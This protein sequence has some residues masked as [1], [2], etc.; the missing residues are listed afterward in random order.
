MA[1]ESSGWILDPSGCMRFRGCPPEY[2]CQTSIEFALESF[3]SGQPHT[4]VVPE[5]VT[6]ILSW[7]FHRAPV[8]EIQ[9]PRSIVEIGHGAFSQSSIETFSEPEGC[10]TRI[11]YGEEV[12]HRCSEL[13]SASFNRNF[14]RIPAFFFRGCRALS[15][16][17][18]PSSVRVV[19][20]GSFWGCQK[21]NTGLLELPLLAEI[22]AASFGES[23]AES[24]SC[25]RGLLHVEPYAFMAC[26]ALTEFDGSGAVNLKRL[27]GRC[28]RSCTSLKRVVFPPCLVFIGYG[29]FMGCGLERMPRLPES[30]MT[31]DSYAF[32]DCAS[33][34]G[35]VA[36][37]A[38]AL[39][40]RGAFSGL[41]RLT[42]A[43]LSRVPESCKETVVKGIF[44]ACPALR[45]VVV[46]PEGWESA[47]RKMAP[48]PPTK[49]KGK[50]KVLHTHEL[51]KHM[52]VH[53]NRQ[54]HGLMVRSPRQLGAIMA[55]LVCGQRK[56][57]LPYMPY[58]MWLM[59]LEMVRRDE[60]G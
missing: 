46:A 29:A 20:Y 12:F 38:K 59:I 10:C 44:P 24:F 33:L 51:P 55:V 11:R 14:D 39:V 54:T 8:K 41:P 13:R 53:W 9:L 52:V 6:C 15:L 16:L 30:L 36:V 28:F 45:A 31:I 47:E 17:R 26:N 49:I 58:E 21:L 37:P 19:G 56:T 57:K 60:L 25:S 1:D 27:P 34:Q 4:I 23:A 42:A 35:E 43:V 32:A 5:G 7:A 48:G 22:D 2:V 40:R 18:L 50:T 3:G